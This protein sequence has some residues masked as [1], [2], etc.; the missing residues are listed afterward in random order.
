MVSV[1]N[2]NRCKGKEPQTRFWCFVHKSHVDG[3]HKEATGHKVIKFDR[4]DPK[5]KERLAN[6][7]RKRLTPTVKLPASVDLRPLMKNG[8]FVT[9]DQGQIGSCTANC[10]CEDLALMTIKQ[11]TYPGVFS[12]TFLYTQ[13]TIDIGTFPQDSGANMIDIS[14]VLSK[15]GCC[16]DSLMP[17]PSNWNP[18]TPTAAEYAAALP[19]V[20]G[21]DTII[22]EDVTSFQT[23]VYNASTVVLLGGLRIG[24]PVNESFMNAVTNGGWVVVPSSGESILGGH[25][26]ECIGYSMMQGPLDKAPQLYFMALQSWGDTGDMASG[27]STF[28]IPWTWFSSSWVA[29][30]GGTDDHQQVALSVTP[31]TATSYNC[32]DGQCVQVNGTGGQYSTLAACQAACGSVPPSTLTLTADPT[33]IT[34]NG[35]V[36]TAFTVTGLSNAE[37]CQV[38]LTASNGDL[39]AESETISDNSGMVTGSL[40]YVGTYTGAATLQ[41]NNNQ[42]ISSNPV[43]ITVTAASTC[44]YGNAVAVILALSMPLIHFAS[45]GLIRA[46]NVVQK[47]RGRQGRFFVIGDSVRYLVV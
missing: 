45:N 19:W 32:V 29:D 47:F 6:A 39:L 9:F 30:Q 13:E 15:Y 23:A 44:V 8:G 36:P 25:A 14:N 10:G 33:T 7:D 21:S 41:A 28:F 2:C 16:S 37:V 1:C 18:T 12:R 26:M 46:L 4:W 35:S 27:L 43:S 3:G 24:I 31:P 42:G 38:L 17:Y 40:S 11:G 22:N 5:H 20:Q 34:N